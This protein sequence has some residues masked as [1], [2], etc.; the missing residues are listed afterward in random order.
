CSN[1]VPSGSSTDAMLNLVLRVS[2]ITRS[3]W[4]VHNEAG[5]RS[6]DEAL[7]PSTLPDHCDTDPVISSLRRLRPTYD[8]SPSALIEPPLTSPPVRARRAGQY[9]HQLRTYRR[10]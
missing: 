5:R 2:S 6:S 7:I 4:M 9:T 1:R 8:G 10:N 3:P